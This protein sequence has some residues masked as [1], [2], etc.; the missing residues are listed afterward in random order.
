MVEL[1]RM[2]E[3]S[4]LSQSYSPDRD[5]LLRTAKASP[6]I[7]GLHDKQRWLALY[8]DDAI[9]E[10]PV[11]TPASQGGRRPGRLGDELGRFYEAFIARSGIDMVARRD[12][13]S[14]MHVFRAVDIHTTHL[15]TGLTMK[16]PAN[17]LYEI[18]ARDGELL[19]RRM[20]AHWELN[21]ISRI[22]MS[23][24]LLGMRTIAAMNFSMLRA[25]GPQWLIAYFQ[26]SQRGV[27]RAGKE[28]IE[29]LASQIDRDRNEAFAAGATVELPGGA[30]AS[31]AEFQ[32]GCTALEVRDLLASGRTVSGLASIEWG[33]RTREAGFVA[34][35]DQAGAEAQRLRWF[36]EE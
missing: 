10:D 36:W 13:V 18:V 4:L 21:R 20:Q 23:Q 9:V 26:A 17:L 32:R 35:L 6:E 22:L 14:G 19:I 3:P 30:T 7:A 29:R 28:L 16:V 31:P 1:E 11:G 8:T 33:G 24:G 2:I 25:F 12:L 27:G 5:A 15:K 34:E